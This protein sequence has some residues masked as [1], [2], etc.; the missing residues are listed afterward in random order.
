MYLNTRAAFFLNVFEYKSG[1]FPEYMSVF[2]L[3]CCLSG[4]LKYE[5]RRAII[6][7]Y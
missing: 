3:N 4:L 5:C 7:M 1:V 2:E 6:N